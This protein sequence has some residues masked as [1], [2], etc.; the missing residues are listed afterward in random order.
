MEELADLL[1]VST[2][3]ATVLH[4]DLHANAVSQAITAQ[5]IRSY[6]V[7][8]FCIQPIYAVIEAT[9]NPRY[10]LPVLLQTLYCLLLSA[11]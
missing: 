7:D 2:E 5:I 9:Y 6:Y 10:H 11:G 4:D 8:L 3:Y 1:R